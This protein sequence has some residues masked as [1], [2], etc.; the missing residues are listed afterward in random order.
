MA[1]RI[2]WMNELNPDLFGFRSALRNKL[3]ICLPRS[4]RIP[5]PSWIRMDATARHIRPRMIYR[6]VDAEFFMA[7]L[8]ILIFTFQDFDTNPEKDGC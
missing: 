6:I 5:L 1:I 2:S 4:A 7:N 3:M 8:Y